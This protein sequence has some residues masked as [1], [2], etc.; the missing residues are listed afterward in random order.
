MNPTEQFN[1]FTFQW[2]ESQ[3]LKLVIFNKTDG[4]GEVKN[5][6]HLYQFNSTPSSQNYRSQ[7]RVKKRCHVLPGQKCKARHMLRNKKEAGENNEKMEEF[8]TRP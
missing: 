7:C 4:G 8:F 5:V 6:L 2:K 3:Q 1:I